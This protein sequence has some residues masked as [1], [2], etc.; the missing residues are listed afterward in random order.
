MTDRNLGGSTQTWIGIVTNVM[1]PHQSGRVQVRVFGRH[2]DTVNIPDSDLPW[3]QVLQP[4][5]SAARGRIGTAPVGL[6]V[7]SRVY[8]QWIDTDRQYPLIFGAVGRAGSTVPGQTSGGSPTVNTAVGS[9]PGATQNN[10][11]NPYSALF[12]NRLSILDIDSGQVDIDSTALGDGA[13]MTEAVEEGMSFP[14]SP[15]TGS[16][17][18]G[19]DDVLAILRRVDPMNSISALPCFTPNAI[20]LQ[21][22]IDLGSIVS[23]FINSITN[24]I[25]NA[26]LRIIDSLGFDSII[27]AISSAAAG[28][29]N[30]RDALDALREGGLC[31][32]PRALASIGAGTQS[33]ARSISSIQTAA[34]RAGRAPQQIRAAL[35]LAGREIR[36]NIATAVF[37][38][39]SILS[40][41]LIPA[42]FVQVYYDADEDPYPGYIRWIDPV[43][44][45][46]DPLFTTRDGQPNF[47]D[48]REHAEFETEQSAFNLFRGALSAG[49]ALTTS[50]LNSVLNQVVDVGQLNALRRTM[51]S[52]F[53]PSSIAGMAFLAARLAPTVINAV[54]G[55]FQPRISVSV[56]T[57]TNIIENATRNFTRVQTSL[58]MRR[59]RFETALR[60]I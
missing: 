22:Q 40:L 17:E 35:G 44:T 60:R 12:D 48:A 27:N 18:P 57:E 38:P 54:Q 42:N 39:L 19:E 1:D 25:T 7:G 31:G 23:G 37:R 47:R 24:S 20:Q 30:F 59:A 49:G 2:D 21:F 5:T 55:N 41:D 26:I 36:S 45:T 16:A 10:V 8:G 33:I 32:A 4:V 52:G 14:K 6:T 34:A 51:G 29:A 9:I 58:A 3:A 28:L 11:S 13:V 46:V 15:T 43:D 56:L 50:T 53:N